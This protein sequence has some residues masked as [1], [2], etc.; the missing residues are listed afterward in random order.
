MKKTKRKGKRKE[1]DEERKMQTYEQINL[2]D[3][4]KKP[5]GRK[6]R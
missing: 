6:K 5:W 4:K 1:Q 3:I 2:R